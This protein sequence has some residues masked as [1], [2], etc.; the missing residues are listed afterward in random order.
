MFRSQPHFYIISYHITILFRKPVHLLFFRHPDKHVTVHGHS[1]PAHCN[2]ILPMLRIPNRQ[3]PRPKLYRTEFSVQKIPIREKQPF[4]S[5][6]TVTMSG[7]EIPVYCSAKLRLC[8]SFLSPHGPQKPPSS[9]LT[10]N[11]SFT[12]SSKSPSRW[13]IFSLNLCL[14]IVLNCSSRITES[15]TMS[16]SLADNST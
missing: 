14:S 2:R 1:M 16:Q 4:H 8:S 15:F 10:F 13:Q 12:W 3:N 11:A 6:Q 7:A 5:C 9:R